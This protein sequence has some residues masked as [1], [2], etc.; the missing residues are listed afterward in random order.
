MEQILITFIQ[1]DAFKSLLTIILTAVTTYFVTGKTNSN[2]YNINIKSLQLEKI[3]L[4]LHQYL[5]NKKDDEI[6]VKVLYENMLLK[7]RKYLLY[8][9]ETYL[10]YLKRIKSE[11]DNNNTNSCQIVKKCRL[12]I[13]YEYSRLKRELGYP[14]KNDFRNSY[15]IFY[16][17]KIIFS[18]LNVILALFFSSFILLGDIY[19]DNDIL[20]KFIGYIVA[21]IMMFDLFTCILYVI[22]KIL[23]YEYIH[24]IM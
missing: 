4:P 20:I 17:V 3:Y 22:Y 9:S 1:S 19:F 8:L 6:D 2:K 15:S 10:Y 21:V 16:I 5:W 12:Y 24:D 18:V 13:D 23:L 7:K 11:I 14:Y